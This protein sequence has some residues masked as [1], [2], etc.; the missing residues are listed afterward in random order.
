[1]KLRKPSPL[2]KNAFKV[3]SIY[4]FAGWWNQPAQ[5]ISR[6]VETADVGSRRGNIFNTQCTYKKNAAGI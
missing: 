3:I 6:K 2:E 4:Y 1:M 5:S